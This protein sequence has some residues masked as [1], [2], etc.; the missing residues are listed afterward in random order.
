[1]L[2]FVRPIEQA[3]ES[4]VNLGRGCRRLRTARTAVIKKRNPKIRIDGGAINSRSGDDVVLAVAG[5]Q[6]AAENIFEE[7]GILGSWK[8]LRQKQPLWRIRRDRLLS[9]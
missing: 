4:D 6:I 9:C 2:F 1:L 3:S 8:V 7:L 5:G